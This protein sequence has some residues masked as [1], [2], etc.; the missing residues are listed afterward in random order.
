[1]PRGY[2]PDPTKSILVVAP[3][4]VAMAED[5]FRGMRLKVVTGSWYLGVFIGY[6][7]AEKS[8]MSVKV[9]GWAEYVGTLAGVAHKHPQSAYI[10]LQKLPQQEWAF[11]QQV[12]PDIGYAF[13]T[14]NKV[15][16]ETFLPALFEGLGKGAPGR[17][18]NRL[19]V[20]H[21][22]LALPE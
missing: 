13:G 14:V 8:W 1:M 11:V 16:Q 5:F 12:N 6:G 20:K 17:G 21:A 9:E 10:R 7:A 3:M 2:F 15:L 4:N 22:R 18:V 19:P